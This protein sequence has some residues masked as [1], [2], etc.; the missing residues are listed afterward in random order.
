[1]K[2]LIFFVFISSLLSGVSVAQT[3]LDV[4]PK[5]CVVSEQHDFCD[6]NLQFKWQQLAVK[7]VCLYQQ[8]MQIRCWQQQGS[9]QFSYK[10]RVQV[11]T[12]YSLINPHTGDSLASVLVEVQSAHTKK[13]YRLRS[14]WSF[15]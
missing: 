12:I 7:D 14:P 6:L 10:A 13:Q 1:M 11:E 15:F 4:S 8:N 3:I 2:Y 9:G 5:V